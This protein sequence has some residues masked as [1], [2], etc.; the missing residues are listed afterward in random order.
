MCEYNVSKRLVEGY[1]HQPYIWFLNRNSAEL[2]KVFYLKY[3]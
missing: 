1:L 3:L 2:G